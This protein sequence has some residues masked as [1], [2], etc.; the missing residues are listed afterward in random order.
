MFFANA[1][2]TDDGNGPQITKRSRKKRKDLLV[3]Y[4]LYKKTDGPISQSVPVD[5]IPQ[6]FPKLRNDPKIV[7]MFDSLVEVPMLPRILLYSSTEY[8]SKLA[9]S[10]FWAVDSAYTARDLGGLHLFTVF[11]VTTCCIDGMPLAYMILPNKSTDTY[12]RAFKAIQMAMP[13]CPVS[14][15]NNCDGGS[16][17][18][19]FINN[20]V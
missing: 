5:I 18:K 4:G 20:P 14:Y 16:Y 15:Y 19:I 10:P 7:L 1:Q 9:E 11:A 2:D 8:M 3:R 6:L 17:I 13:G 12:R